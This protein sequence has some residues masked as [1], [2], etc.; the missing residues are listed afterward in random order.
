ME[1]K[2]R[3]R[4]KRVFLFFIEY[5]SQFWC[6]L[7]SDE[8]SFKP[9]T[10]SMIMMKKYKKY[11]LDG[12]KNVIITFET[13]MLAYSYVWKI[14]NNVQPELW[15]RFLVNKGTVFY[16]LIIF[17]NGNMVNNWLVS[18]LCNVHFYT[19]KPQVLRKK[20]KA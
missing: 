2:W 20:L 11:N 10:W 8:W 1:T 17:L 6:L 12:I 16:S 9:I 14:K 5:F 7:L 3:R 13:F 19:F 4:Q 18:F 15:W